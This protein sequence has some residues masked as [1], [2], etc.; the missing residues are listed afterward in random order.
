MIP[1]PES[2]VALMIR[3]LQNTQVLMGL[4]C[5]FCSL[6]ALVALVMVC[7]LWRYRRRE[8]IGK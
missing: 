6:A 4:T 2:E 5:V 1:I 3:E 7:T 8:E